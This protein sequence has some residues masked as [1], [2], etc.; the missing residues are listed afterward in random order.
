[1]GRCYITCRALS[2]SRSGVRPAE[3]LVVQFLIYI[4]I[5]LIMSQLLRSPIPT[6][7]DGSSDQMENEALLSYGRHRGP[8]HAA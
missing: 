1:M 6:F 2:K 3:Y 7:L 8:F 5:A 4:V